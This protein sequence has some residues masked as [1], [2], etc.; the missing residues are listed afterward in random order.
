MLMV[1]KFFNF[2]SFWYILGSTFFPILRLEKSGPG[3]AAKAQFLGFRC[4]VS[5]VR[6]QRC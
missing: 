2:L 5:G 1:T 3:G 6:E 4:Q